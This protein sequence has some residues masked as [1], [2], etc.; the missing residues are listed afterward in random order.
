MAEPVAL[1]GVKA[2]PHKAEVLAR[3]KLVARLLVKHVGCTSFVI[4]ECKAKGYSRRTVER[5]IAL[6]RARWQ[7]EAEQEAPQR[8]EANRRSL[9]RAIRR[10]ES[11]GK[12]SASMQG[13]RTL[14][15]L[16]G[17]LVEKIQTGSLD[18]YD[19]TLLTDEELAT[20]RALDAKARRKA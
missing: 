5:D 10:A 19:P 12:H 4:E 17:V 1:T 16:D 15:Q 14:A 7:R 9:L 11:D 6:V 13:R 3:R 18:D 20:K 8:R 2:H